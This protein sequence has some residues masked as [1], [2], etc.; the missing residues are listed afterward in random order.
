MH[1]LPAAAL[2]ETDEIKNILNAPPSPFFSLSHIPHT[3]S[4]HYTG[5]G[6]IKYTS[7][8]FFPQSYVTAIHT[9]HVC[10]NA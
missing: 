2:V 10:G 6:K 1:L 3:N 5:P 9:L 4:R 7:I 8:T